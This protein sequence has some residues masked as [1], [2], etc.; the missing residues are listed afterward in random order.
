MNSEEKN[1]ED[2]LKLYP[3]NILQKNR[4]NEENQNAKKISIE[5]IDIINK[6]VNNYNDADK[7]EKMNLQKEYK[8]LITIIK[9]LNDKEL[10]IILHYLNQNNI[11]ILEILITDFLESGIYIENQEDKIKEIIAKS[12]NILF[13]KDIFYFVYEKLSYAFRK[14]RT[15]IDKNYIKNF[16]KIFVIWKL[17]YNIEIYNYHKNN[18]IFYKTNKDNN[19]IFINIGKVGKVGKDIK[20]ETGH[21]TDKYEILI[22]LESSSL[23]KLNKFN[24]NFR[25]LI[26]YDDKKENNYEIKYDDVFSE[27]NKIDISKISEIKIVLMK[28]QVIITINNDEK[29]NRIK[30][31]NFDIYTISKIELLNNFYGEISSIKILKS[32]IRSPDYEKDQFDK[33]KKQELFIEIKDYQL[34]FNLKLGNVEQHC[35]IL[36]DIVKYEGDIFSDDYKKISKQNNLCNIIYYGG[37]ECFIPLI[38]LINYIIQ[39]LIINRKTAK[40]Q[41]MT[42]NCYFIK[43][44]IQWIQDIL[45]IILKMICLSEDNYLN[46]QK[47]VISLI[48]S[49]AEIIHTLKDLNNFLSLLLQDEIF[50]IFYILILNS[51][52]PNNVK[53]IY[54]D[55]FKIDENF[56]NFKFSMEPLIFNLNKYPIEKIEWYFQ[57]LFNFTEFL[58]LYYDS[59]NKIPKQLINQLIE[60]YL[61]M[62]KELSIL[63]ANINI[64]N[65]MNMKNTINDKLKASS[66]FINFIKEYCLE[67]KTNLEAIFKSNNN[68]LKENK[69]YFNY[70]ISMIETFLNAYNLKESLGFIL[71]LNI[72]A[73]IQKLIVNN[74]FDNFEGFSIAINEKNEYDKIIKNHFKDY[75]DNYNFLQEIF[76]FLTIE[77]FTIKNKLIMN[78]LIDYHGQYHHIMK[79]LF[80]FN[81]LWSDK[82]LFFKNNLEDIKNSKLKFKNI[83]YYTRNFQ[84]PILY[85]YLDYKYNYPDFS[86]FKIKNEKFYNSDETEDDYNFEIT[87]K[88]LDELIEK[89]DNEIIGKIDNIADLKLFSNICLVKQ[90]Y[91]VKG[92]LFIIKHQASKT[93]MIYFYS[94]PYNFQ[95]KTESCNNK[96]NNNNKCYGSIFKCPKKE[97]NRKITIDLDDVRLFL[98]RIYFYSN[99]AIEIFTETKSYYFNFSK[100]STFESFFSLSLF[101]FKNVYFPLSRND[102]PF[103]IIKLNQKILDSLLEEDKL[104]Y[105]KLSEKDNYFIEFF[106]KKTSKGELFEMCIFDLLILLNLISNR[107]YIDL[108]Q[109]PVFPLLFFYDKKESHEIKRDFKKHIGLQYTDSS[110]SKKRYENFNKT[111]INSKKDPDDEE[112]PHYFNTHYSNIVYTCNY[113]IRL[114]PYSFISIELQGNG[115]DDPNRLFFS[116]EDTL[117]NIST[118]KSDLRE[119]IPEFFYFP[120]I[121][122][123]INHINFHKRSNNEPVDDVILINQNI[124]KNKSQKKQKNEI[125]INYNGQA[126][127]EKYFHFV[128]YMKNKLESLNEKINDWINIIFGT[129]QRFNKKKEQYFRT[130]SYIDNDDKTIQKYINNNIIMDSVEFGLIPL[131]I[132]FDKKKVVFKKRKNSQLNESNIENDIKNKNRKKSIKYKNEKIEKVEEKVEENEEETEKEE[133]NII[134]DSDLFNDNYFNEKINKYKDYW[135]DPL[136]I[137]FEICNQ[138]NIGKLRV[139]IND[140]INSE[141]IDHNNTI[142]DYYYNRRLNMFATTSPDGFICVYMLP[143]KLITMIKNPNNS[144]YSQVLLS[145]NPLPSIIAF[146][147][148]DKILT[149]YSLSGIMINTITITNVGN[150]EL[151]IDPIFNIYGGIFKDRINISYNNELFKVLNVPF[152]N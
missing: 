145:S 71:N 152:F 46:F 63:L 38:K 20:K 55:L 116:I 85:P 90:A 124:I 147:K 103:G 2:Y 102:E 36:K 11:P 149:S 57:F 30:K 45:K 130:E 115:F 127:N 96:S 7:K 122:M 15:I 93:F 24:K 80:I 26:L 131:Q 52:L 111:F 91:H 19:N 31:I 94:L 77:N 34:N 135:D 50:F 98:K 107:S 125:L 133:N 108:H 106:S 40:N 75:I 12:I 27:N 148:K 1:K 4:I 118:Q 69:Y 105:S 37:L 142:I 120:E 32:F 25:F 49:I 39:K 100:K 54:K 18:I 114:F 33:I 61:Y 109:Y 58:M 89:Y 139:K 66:P 81:R 47:I 128:E 68:I 14:H 113:L 104:D 136:P 97:G 126:K 88:E 112:D 64:A 41:E 151:K 21:E 43:K 83:N 56:T 44:S 143:N 29:N 74:I 72:Y 86:L 84:R 119:L 137:K 87:C 59:T 78:E 48:G 16:E 101:P 70:I 3:N 138:N 146:N 53:K 62:E 95:E 99:S 73:N 67:E 129:K 141:I 82:S 35:N 51:T 144:Y 9:K 134:N 117:Y 132:I 8:S 150:K 42:I 13:N 6:F 140:I 92:T 79:E 123:N 76:P 5:D 121:F 17:L 10:L 23:M 60:I 65:I 22:K 110:E 28:N